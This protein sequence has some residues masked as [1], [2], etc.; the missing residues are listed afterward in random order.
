M[1]I[2]RGEVSPSLQPGAAPVF[3]YPL[4]GAPLVGAGARV[5]L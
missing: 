3:R 4:L 5:N 1:L 2:L